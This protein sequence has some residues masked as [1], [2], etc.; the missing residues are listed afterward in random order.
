MLHALL[1]LHLVNVMSSS[2]PINT[3]LPVKKKKIKKI[4][5]T[6][7]KKEKKKEKKRI[8]NI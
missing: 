1:H 4:K 6:K 8:N 5:K 7:K 2:F 3:L